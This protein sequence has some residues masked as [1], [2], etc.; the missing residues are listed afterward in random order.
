MEELLF[1]FSKQ[2]TEKKDEFL[3]NLEQAEE[4]KERLQKEINAMEV[5]RVQW[6]KVVY[7]NVG[8]RHFDVAL[9]TLTEASSFNACCHIFGK[10]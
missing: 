1:D 7:L 6:G 8:G 10:T 4:Y 3:A 5:V 2:I 9:S